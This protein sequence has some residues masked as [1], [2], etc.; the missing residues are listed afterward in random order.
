MLTKKSERKYRATITSKGALTQQM[1]EACIMLKA[2]VPNKDAVS[3]IEYN[4]QVNFYNNKLEELKKL[5]AAYNEKS[6]PY[7]EKTAQLKKNA[8]ISRITKTIMRLR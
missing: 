2:E 8:I 5:E 6:G 3:L 4:K 7:L 1:I